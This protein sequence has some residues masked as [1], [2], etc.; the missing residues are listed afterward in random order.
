M[1]Q[2]LCATALAVLVGGAV[3]AA[4]GGLQQVPDPTPGWDTAFVNPGDP[5]YYLPSYPIA[6]VKSPVVE[7]SHPLCLIGSSCYAYDPNNPQTCSG[8]PFP[9]ATVGHYHVG[10][11]VLSAND[12]DPGNELWIYLPSVGQVVK[13]FPRPIHEHSVI[14]FTAAVGSVVEPSLSE[15]GRRIYFAYFQD[16]TDANS[17]HQDQM[18]LSRT[19]A[20]LY[21]IDIGPLLSQPL[22]NPDTL[23]VTRLTTRNYVFDH[24]YMVQDP[25]DRDKAAMNPTMAQQTSINETNWGTVFMHPTEFRTRAGLRLA[26]VSNERRLANSNQQM[27]HSNN[28]FNIHVAPIL[29]DGTLG[30]EDGQFQYY[31]TTSAL[32]PTPLR[33]GLAFSYQASTDAM[34]MWHIQGMDSEG[35][36]FPII[37]YGSNPEVYHLATFCVTNDNGVLG[38]RLV[39]ARYYNGS[40]EGFGALWSQDLSIR[41]K[42][43]Y[44]D[45]AN[46]VQNNWYVPLQVG[47]QLL[48]PSPL[49][50]STDQPSPLRSP[51]V[52]YGKF[53]S[54]RC[55]G[56]DELYFSYT[57][58]GANYKSYNYDAECNQGRYR[59]RIDFRPNLNWFNPGVTPSPENHYDGSSIVIR[60]RNGDSNLVWPVP[61]VP[62]STRSNGDAT[63]RVATKSL[64]TPTPDIL[65]G[66]PFARIGTSAMGNTDRRPW[67]CYLR[68]PASGARLYFNPWGNYG[69]GQESDLITQNQAPW[70][71]VNVSPPNNFCVPPPASQILGLVINITSDKTNLN[72]SALGYTSDGVHF[73]NGQY[74][75]ATEAS[76]LLGIY[77][78]RNQTDQSAFALIPSNVPIELQA[79]DSTYGMKL[80]DQASWHS[81]KPQETRTDCGGCHQHAADAPSPVR[82]ENSYASTQPPLDLVRSTTTISYDAHCQIQVDPPTRAPAVD[83]PEWRADIW[84]GLNTYCG[85]CHNSS[86]SG[87]T[88]A[89]NALSWSD[90]SIPTSDL[91]YATLNLRKYASS[92]LGALGSP[93]FWAARG[94]RTDNR[95]NTAAPANV[96]CTGCDDK[97]RYGYYYS[98]IHDNLGN[99][100]GH[101][102]TTGDAAYASWLFKLGK[103]IDN[104]MPRDTGNT[105]P[106]PIGYK[107][108]WYHPTADA[109]ISTSNCAATQL[110]VG[111]W[112]DSNALKS[113]S[114]LLN[115]SR[116]IYSA[117]WPDSSHPI[118]NGEVLLSI[119]GVSSSDWITVEVHDA[120][121][122][123]QIY[124]KRVDQLVAECTPG[125]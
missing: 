62:W 115:D 102:C 18:T 96:N 23:V 33:N 71:W 20:D 66:E 49:S 123:R 30:P 6:F 15:D 35:Y 90:T 110:R 78:V 44:N 81:L 47:S 113:I 12:P 11:D 27:G 9:N 41:G 72:D 95:D 45:P 1:G 60:K 32:S 25:A 67:E 2:K 64:I 63:Q 36:W 59:A 76:R 73:G 83:Y 54:P 21:A 122:N 28:N 108:D 85:G 70:T 86:S 109:A 19:G 57:P 97:T 40:N 74:G 50:L 79:I 13:L 116:S 93:L 31:T 34:R 104:H 17:T 38:D 92:G 58:T 5:A 7:W 107:F 88:T 101:P 77:D 114:V 52:F 125:P 118:Q 124:R 100:A 37:G 91:V 29:P 8:T 43:T 55:G 121:D 87:N 80:T 75:R 65:P 16:A 22:T 84:Q 56:V 94:R 61:I 53:T 4:P 106:N 26:Y 48:T 111:W 82:F 51:G 3:S 69:V 46:L 98:S 42:N 103:W 14:D 39:A 112:D 120:A 68:Q 119:L 89:Q 117:Q 99:S 105:I 24:G 10:T